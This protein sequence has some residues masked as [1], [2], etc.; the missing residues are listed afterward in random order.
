MRYVKCKS[1]SCTIW[2]DGHVGVKLYN[3]VFISCVLL[4]LLCMKV[5]EVD[6]TEAPPEAKRVLTDEAYLQGQLDP[7]LSELRKKMQATTDWANG[8]G[9]ELITV[10]NRLICICSLE[11]FERYM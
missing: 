9:K 5:D 10:L 1:N 8:P 4:S 3:L 2:V 7:L 6:Q 11:D